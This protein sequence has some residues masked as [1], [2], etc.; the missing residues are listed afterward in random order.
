VH[1]AIESGEIEAENARKAILAWWRAG[2]AVVQ[3]EEGNINYAK[4]MGTRERTK[5]AKRISSVLV[6]D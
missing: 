1:D 2:R 6:K 5:S 4:A 3:E